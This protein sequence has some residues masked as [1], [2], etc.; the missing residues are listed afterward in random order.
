M[1]LSLLFMWWIGHHSSVTGEKRWHGAIGLFI[2]AVG[3]LL[4]TLVDDNRFVIAGLCLAAIGVYAPFGVWWS[5]PSTFLSGAA[6]AGA[7]GMINACGNLG[8]FLGPYLT[9]YLKEQTGSFT[10]AWIY[11]AGS[12]FAAGIMMLKLTVRK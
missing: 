9:G 5:Y 6:A 1:S 8:G 3:M 4:G 7:I 2:A 12:L 10:F 11:L